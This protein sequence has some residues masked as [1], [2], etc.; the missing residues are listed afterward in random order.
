[1]FRIILPSEAFLLSTVKQEQD[2]I[3]MY[4]DKLTIKQTIN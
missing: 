1:M 2:T 3:K 4:T